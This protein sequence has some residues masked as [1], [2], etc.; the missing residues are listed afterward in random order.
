MIV[1]TQAVT[2]W[3]FVVEGL[4]ALALGVGFLWC[5]PPR[6]KGALD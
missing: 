3:P 5:T 1:T 6:I 4:L 2:L